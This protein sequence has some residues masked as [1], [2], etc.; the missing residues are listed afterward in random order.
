MVP[1][2]IYFGTG[3][4]AESAS[5]DPAVWDGAGRQNV[6][7]VMR[8]F[9]TDEYGRP[10]REIVMGLDTYLLPDLPPQARAKSGRQM[11]DAAY[12]QLVARA[13]ADPPPGSG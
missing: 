1:Y 4:T 7:V 9:G 6:Q 13:M 12:W 10:L 5:G 3:S 8:Y 2:R 11:A